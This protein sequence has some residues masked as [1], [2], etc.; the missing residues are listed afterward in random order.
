MKEQDSIYKAESNE[1]K[2]LFV[3][4]DGTAA[5]FKRVDTL[6]TLYEKG[7]FLDLKPIPNV[8][9]AVKRIIEQHPDVE[10]YSLSSVLT[11]SRYAVEEKNDWMDKYI[12]EIDKSHRL[13]PPCGEKKTDYVIWKIGQIGKNDFLLDDYTPNLKDWEPPGRGIKMLNGINHTKGT[14]QSSML[15]N[16]RTPESL[17]GG[18]CRCLSGEIVLDMKS[19]IVAAKIIDFNLDR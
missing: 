12:P 7:Y 2:R 6:E 15:S 9:E 1:K 11:D 16:I 3:D 8:V 13:F 10:V 19:N 14:W 4:L 17:E 18:I 5:E